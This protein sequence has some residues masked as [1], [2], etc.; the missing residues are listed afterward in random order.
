MSELYRR[1][2]EHVSKLPPA[3]EGRPKA[4]ES[5]AWMQGEWQAV[6][7]DYEAD[8]EKGRGIFEAGRGP[9]TVGFTP[10]QRWLRI[11]SELRPNWLNVRY[12]GYDRAARQFVLHEITSPGQV[13]VSPMRS[14]GWGGDRVIFGPADLLFYGLPL[15]DR[16]TFV[17]Q[18]ND[19]FRVVVEAR[20]PDG[21]LMAV[22]DMVYTRVK[23]A[24]RPS[25]PSAVAGTPPPAAA[26]SQPPGTFDTS[27][28]AQVR[29]ELTT[30]HGELNA[31]VQ[32]RDRA[33]IERGYAPEFVFI[34]AYGYVD[35]LADHVEMLLARDPASPPRILTFAQLSVHGDVA[36][37]RQRGGTTIGTP[38]LGTTI[39]VRRNG[40]WQILQSQ[41]TEMVP[42]RTAVPVATAVLDSYVGRYD[43]GGGVVVEIRR[44]G[45]TLFRVVPGLPRV[46]MTPASETQFFDKT[47]T[48]WT[49]H[50]DPAG[51]VTHYVSRFRDREWRGTRI[52]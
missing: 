20:L 43:R 49:F 46:R 11:E 31:A 21:T 40:R 50:R 15:T 41:G 9:A 37:N 30:L 52:D 25:V 51:R 33:A 4:L 39:Y 23:S 8:A 34:H 48:E 5:F 42:E 12:I 13:F 27:Q 17:R 36:V 19:A 26:S 3:E 16:I 24:A 38:T 22:D 32:A 47:G 35:S 10:D 14:A 45:D 29:E 6:A 18:G 44:E 7:R 28:L 2:G 1:W